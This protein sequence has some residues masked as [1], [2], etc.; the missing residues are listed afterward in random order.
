[1]KKSTIFASKLVTCI[2]KQICCTGSTNHTAGG[3][4]KYKHNKGKKYFYQ[5]IWNM[6]KIRRYAYWIP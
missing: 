6:G 2:Y 4:S 5:Q 3:Y 1:M